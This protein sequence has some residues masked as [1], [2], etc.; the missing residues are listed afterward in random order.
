MEK[1]F[2]NQQ[3]FKNKF[4]CRSLVVDQ[5]NAPLKLDKKL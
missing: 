2:K 5:Y 3:N 4:I 1:T